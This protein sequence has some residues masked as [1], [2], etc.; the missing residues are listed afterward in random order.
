MRPDEARDTKIYY[1]LL[2]PK[3]LRT[4]SSVFISMDE[5]ESN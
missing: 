2:V 3:F 5:N 4:T 1:Y